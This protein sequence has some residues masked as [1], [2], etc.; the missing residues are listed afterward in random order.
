MQYKIICRS[1]VK[2]RWALQ[3]AIAGIHLI[4]SLVIKMNHGSP[5]SYLSHFV[6]RL[7]IS[8]IK[9]FLTDI[10]NEMLWKECI[11]FNIVLLRPILSV[12]N[13]CYP[14]IPRCLVRIYI[15]CV[16]VH[17]HT[18]TRTIKHKLSHFTR[19]DDLVFCRG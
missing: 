18:H 12:F 3:K 11:M 14:S 6:S 15:I 19:L 10:L 9:S 13:I 16:C 7:L 1:P 5:S 8:I 17:V 2:W 4:F